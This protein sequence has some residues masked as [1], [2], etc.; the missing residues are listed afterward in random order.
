MWLW[1]VVRHLQFKRAGAR[2]RITRS[3][4]R[5]LGVDQARLEQWHPVNFFPVTVGYAKKLAQVVSNASTLDN[6]CPHRMLL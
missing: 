4:S 1:P 2:R 6:V 5:G 3:G